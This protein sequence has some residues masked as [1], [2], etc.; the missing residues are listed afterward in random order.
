MSLFIK[1]FLKMDF[2]LKRLKMSVAIAMKKMLIL[3][4]VVMIPTCD[5][6]HTRR[7]GLL[8]QGSKSIAYQ[9]YPKI[10][11]IGIGLK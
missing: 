5:Y 9:P 3:Q 8:F 10:Q 6:H 11:V 2:V 4:M 7:N 1:F